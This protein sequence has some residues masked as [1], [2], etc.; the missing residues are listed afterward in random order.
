LKFELVRVG[1]KPP[2]PLWAVAVVAIWAALGLTALGLGHW[3]ERPVALCLF[4]RLTGVPCPTCGF[5]RGMLSLAGGHPIR[6][7]LFNPLLFSVLGVFGAAVLLRLIFQRAVR[8]QLTRTQR[9]TTWATFAT[10]F[11]LNW[12]YVML[13]TG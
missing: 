2:W 12:I 8:V 11:V 1:R 6:A 9:I 13:C 7:W 4:K 5:T 10:L 3:L